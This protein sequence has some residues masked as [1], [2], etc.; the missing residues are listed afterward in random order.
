MLCDPKEIA[1]TSSIRHK[2]CFNGVNCDAKMHLRGLY[3]KHSGD[4]FRCTVRISVQVT[5]DEPVTILCRVI[6]GFEMLIEP[7]LAFP[8]MNRAWREAREFS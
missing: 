7:G 3:W 6:I 5:Q 2:P 1:D 4:Q 8:A